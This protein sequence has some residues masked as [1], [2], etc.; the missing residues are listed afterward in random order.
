MF[1]NRSI[2]PTDRLPQRRRNHARLGRCA[3]PVCLMWLEE[4][5][6]L[7]IGPPDPS[8]SAP[9]VLSASVMNSAGPITLG[10]ATP[11][12]ITQGGVQV[13]AIEPGSDGRLIVEALPD[14]TALELRLSLYDGQGN[15]LVQSDGQSTGRLDPS[16][17]QHVAVGTDFIEVQSLAGSG[18]FTLST[19]LTPSSDPGGTVPTPTGFQGKYAP[20]AAGDF[21]NNGVL[22]IVTPDGVHLGT[23]D[24]TFGSPVGGTTLVDSSS[25][26]N[27][28]AIAVG[29]FNSDGDLDV[30]FALAGTDSIAIFLGNGD[31]TFQPP[32]LIGLP[33]GSAARC[34]RDGR[35]PGQ[36][37]HR[38]GRR[39]RR[40]QLDHDYSEH[41]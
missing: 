8:A 15:L 3:S 9:L 34:D 29:N 37:T 39:R 30:A 36:R 35:F 26:A 12:D 41:G 14:S 2:R 21:T 23:G 16:I 40:H 7:S 4:R 10:A 28:S 6:L 38:S 31:G 19:V 11:L 24:G 32:T 20:I 22:D 5:V 1:L 13:Y 25:P 17:D 33:T 27:P 18:S